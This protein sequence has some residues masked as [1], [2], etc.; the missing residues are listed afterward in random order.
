VK[1]QWLFFLIPVAAWAAPSI[2]DVSWSGSLSD[3]TELTITGTDFGAD[4]PTVVLF[5][6]FEDGTVPNAIPADRTAPVGQYSGTQGTN[7]GYFSST[8]AYSGAQSMQHDYTLGSSVYQEVLFSPVDPQEVLIAYSWFCPSGANLP[9]EGHEEQTNWKLVWLMGDDSAADDDVNLPVIFGDQLDVL[10]T[11]NDTPLDALSLYVGGPDGNVKGEW[12][13]YVSYIKAGE[14]LDGVL[15]LH[16]IGTSG[17]TV[18]YSSQTIT[19]QNS[20]DQWE[21]FHVPGYGR[22]NAVGGNSY[23][24]F[25]DIYIATGAARARV[26]VTNNGTYASS[27]S[28]GLGTPTAWS[29]TSMSVVFRQGNL[30]T[31]AAYVYVVDTDGNRSSGF[32]VTIGAEAGSG[33]QRPSGVTVR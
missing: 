17:V 1:W 25:D 29:D 21:R 3:G 31:G 7:P 28:M 23:G 20:G 9:G 18:R 6:D 4:G 32:E 14:S 33:T 27:T 15:E 22:D 24:N 11:G 8:S 19:T 5:D 10:I 2:S 13:R 30:T 26:E 16:E 12:H